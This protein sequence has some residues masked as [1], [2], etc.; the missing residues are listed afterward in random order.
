MAVQEVHKFELFDA[1]DI[2]EN[3]LN[4][5]M[6]RGESHPEGQYH[7]VIEIIT[8]NEQGQI[9]LTKR[10]PRKVFGNYWEI[11]GGSV[12]KGEDVLSGAVRELEEETGLKADKN[13]FIPIFREV[14]YD[15]IFKGFFHQIDTTN[16]H[17][18]IQ[19][20]EIIDYQWILKCDFIEFI[21]KDHFVPHSKNRILRAWAVLEPLIFCE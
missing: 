12:L 17:F 19:D 4:I 6:V 16:Q 8:M 3:K 9:L 2:D 15:G 21:C 1:Y 11:T 10:H 7:I 13:N 5:D 14:F 20:E 18:K